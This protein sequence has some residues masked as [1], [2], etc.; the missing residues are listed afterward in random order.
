MGV[1]ILGYTQ[2]QS[3]ENIEWERQQRERQRENRETERRIKDLRNLGDRRDART[4]NA[5]A[6]PPRVSPAKLTDEQ[7][8]L[9][10]PSPL[11][12]A[13]SATFLSQPNTGL[14]RLLPREKYDHTV[15]MPLRG[16]GAYYSFS[17]LSQEA[18]P[19][20]DIKFQEGHLQAGVNHLTLG[21]MTMLG[22]VPLENIDLNNPA[23]QFISQL[24]VPGKYSDHEHYVDRYRSGF[25]AGVNSYQS[26]LPAQ[27]N[28][29]YILRSTV[30]DKVDS[31][32][33]FRV[34]RSETGGSVT[35][36]W[37]MLSKLPVK[38]LKDI[39]RDYQ[40]PPF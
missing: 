21:L 11:D 25:S 26:T 8:A 36:L 7:K 40:D 16:G 17:K 32:V 18:S 2:S 19:W 1:P 29:T 15:Q 12:E 14:I 37:K 33:A 30:Y 31:V 39:P 38:K 24:P 4:I 35:L 34:I 5:P 10:K 27:L 20:S 28:A 6:S 3:R 13:T 22:E 9:L 23:V